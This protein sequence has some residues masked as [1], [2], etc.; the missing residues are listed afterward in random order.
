MERDE[1]QFAGIAYEQ[2]V[3]ELTDQIVGLKGLVLHRRKVYAGKETNHEVDISFEYTTGKVALLFVIECKD[4]TRPVQKRDVQAFLH[5]IRDI[6]AHKGIIVSRSGYQGGAIAVA[7]A[8][9]IALLMA[10]RKGDAVEILHALVP[11]W[12][13]FNIGLK[14]AGIKLSSYPVGDRGA[15][16]FEPVEYFGDTGTSITFGAIPTVQ[17]DRSSVPMLHQLIVDAIDPNANDLRARFYG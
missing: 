11:A 9:G 16:E 12:A 13:R 5:V 15:L 7:R 10:A 17:V 3:A 2:L 4:W 8:N 14:K 1:D 6:G